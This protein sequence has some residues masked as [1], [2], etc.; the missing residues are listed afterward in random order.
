[1]PFDLVDHRAEA[2]T[3]DGG[4]AAACCQPDPL[5]VR[6]QLLPGAPREWPDGCSGG[7]EGAGAWSYTRHCRVLA[8]GTDVVWIVGVAV[9]AP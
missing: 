1:M 7:N 6:V 3:I 2:V 5:A 9:A 8:D 4:A